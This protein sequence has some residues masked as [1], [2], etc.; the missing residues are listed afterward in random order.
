MFYE[1]MVS[2]VIVARVFSRNGTDCGTSPI[3][4]PC[5]LVTGIHFYTTR[6]PCVFDI[7]AISS[8]GT[9]VSSSRVKRAIHAICPQGLASSEIM[10]GRRYS[11]QQFSLS[12]LGP[13]PNCHQGGNLQAENLLGGTP[14]PLTAFVTRDGIPSTLTVNL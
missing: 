6:Y 14:D 5:D 8:H 10:T 13:T 1:G 4:T 7:D 12:H 2:D 9:R 11:S 3:E